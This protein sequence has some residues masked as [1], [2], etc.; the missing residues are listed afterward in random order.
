MPDQNDLKRELD[1]WVAPNLRVK[2]RR[3]TAE[4]KGAVRAQ[5]ER[6]SGVLV[7]PREPWAERGAAE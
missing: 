1:V 3:P 2:P 6:L 5:E 7:R 4:P